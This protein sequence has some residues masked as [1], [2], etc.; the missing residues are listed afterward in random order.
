MAGNWL[1]MAEF[2]GKITTVWHQFGMF[3]QGFATVFYSRNREV[4][5]GTRGY[6]QMVSQGFQSSA[7]VPYLLPPGLYSGVFANI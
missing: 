4:R 6:A 1:R 3:W 7:K 2:C 5:V